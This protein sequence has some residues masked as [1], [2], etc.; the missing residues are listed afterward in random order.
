MEL[1]P[2]LTPYLDIKQD[3]TDIRKLK[4]YPTFYL[5]TMG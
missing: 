1:Y 2:I 3:S 4:Q 5:T